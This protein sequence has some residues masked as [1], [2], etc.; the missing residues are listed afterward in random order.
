MMSTNSLS[1]KDIKRNWHLI[2]ANGKVLG[3][4]ATVVATILMGKDKSNY[5]SYLD[6]GDFVI[7][8]NA[9]KVKITGKK[10]EQKK[11]IHHSGYPGGYKEENFSRLIKRRPEEVIRHAVSGMLPKTKLGKKM[12]KKLHVYADNKHKFQNQLGEGKNG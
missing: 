1:A 7:I 10:A 3:R 6:T 2:D 11:Y 5:V 9:A 12:I 4:L 8:T